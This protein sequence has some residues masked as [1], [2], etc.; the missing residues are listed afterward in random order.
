VSASRKWPWI[1]AAVI[2]TAVL[3]MFLMRSGSRQEIS[4]SGIVPGGGRVPA[5]GASPPP[6]R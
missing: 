6:E 4:G 1:L 3:A 5:E 2:V